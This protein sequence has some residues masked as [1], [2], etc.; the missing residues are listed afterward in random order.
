MK[1]IMKNQDLFKVGEDYYLAHCI[2]A[3]FALGAGIAVQFN[4]RFYTKSQ[5]IREYP[6]YLSLWDSKYVGRGDCILT[7]HHVFNLVTKRNYWEKPTYVS[8]HSALNE[9]KKFI[10]QFGIKKLAMPKIGCG[11]DRLEWRNVEG[12]IK[13]IFEDVDIEIVVC[14]Q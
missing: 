10:V 3:D 4:K 5:L 11:L 14:Y 7:D 12:M 1:L 2:S 6:G 9:M 13:T 8:L